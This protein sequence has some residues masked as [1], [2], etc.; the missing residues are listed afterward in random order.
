MDINMR[1]ESG[2]MGALYVIS[3]WI[4]RFSIINILWFMFS[5]PAIFILINMLLID[6]LEEL[7]YLVVP[8]IILVPVLLFPA[9]TAMF[10]TVRNWIIKD[11]DQ[12]FKTYWGFYKENYK[13]SLLG[14]IIIMGIWLIW[15]VDIYYFSNISTILLYLF[16]FIGMILFIFTINFFSITVHYNLKLFTSLKNSLFVT[17]GSPILFIVL[18]S[19]IG[20][21]LYISIYTFQF[22]LPFFTGSLIAYISFA[23]FYKKYLKLVEKQESQRTV[24]ITHD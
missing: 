17:I 7:L 6:Q 3:R 2:I 10:A 13:R 8:S 1:N 21:I 24:Y 16:W 18:I 19:C 11:S 20:L 14:G 23:V 4:M 22:L 5:L 15:L 9:T 12:L